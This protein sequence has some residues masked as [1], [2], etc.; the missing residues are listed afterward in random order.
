[1]GWRKIIDEI[2]FW[3]RWDFGFL[4]K[5]HLPQ[6]KQRKPIQRQ[7]CRHW[8]ACMQLGCTMV[9]HAERLKEIFLKKHAWIR[10]WVAA[11]NGGAVF[12]LFFS[13][14]DYSYHFE[15]TEK[16]QIRAD[17]WRRVNMK[18]HISV[19][20]LCRRRRH[21]TAYTELHFRMSNS[22]SN[23]WHKS[24]GKMCIE[25]FHRMCV[26]LNV[27]S[28][29]SSEVTRLTRIAL[30]CALA[31]DCFFFFS[32]SQT[33]WLS[34]NHFPLIL[35]CKQ[36][37]IRSNMPHS[38]HCNRAILTASEALPAQIFNLITVNTE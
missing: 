4:L 9:L 19:F 26:Q 25:L 33:G 17:L 10:S 5:F 38:V 28:S 6:Q 13:R 37:F 32:Y 1:M 3:P 29:I 11:E 18:N 2:S 12:L 21:W 35:K 16:K 30:Q 8:G 14:H 34:A 27:Q 15:W 24:A 31:I 36:Q 7:R 22:N 20:S 23:G